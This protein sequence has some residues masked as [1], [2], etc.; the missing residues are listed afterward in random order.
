KITNA[1]KLVSMSKLQ[2]YQRRIKEFSEIVAEYED[3]P[4]EKMAGS[5]K[6]DVLAVCFVPD[7][8]LVSGYNNAITKAARELNPDAIFWLGSQNYE[9]ISAIPDLNVV[10]EKMQSDHLHIDFLY[11]DIVDYLKEYQVFL[12]NIY[13]IVFQ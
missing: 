4:S 11:D 2:K 10:N 3:I 8:G 9:K 5:E 1:M 6:L 12:D 7:L 13:I